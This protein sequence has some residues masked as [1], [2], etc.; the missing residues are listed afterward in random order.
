MT[1]LELKNH[2]VWQDLTEI[3]ENIDTNA[4]ITEHLELCDYKVCGYWDYDDNFFEQI[5]LPRSLSAE[6]ISSS[7][8]TTHKSRWI[9]LKFILKAEINSFEELSNTNYQKVG[10]ISLIF[11]ENMEFIDENWQID[12]GSPFIITKCE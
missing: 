1:K 9:Q 5:I 2:Q 11:D 4:L 8:G 3:L 10:E 7:V 12:I 6:L